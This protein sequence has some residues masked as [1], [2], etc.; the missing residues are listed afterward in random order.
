MSP[1]ASSSE[2]DGTNGP[3][4]SSQSHQLTSSS[5]LEGSPAPV[6][7]QPSTSRQTGATGPPAAPQSPRRPYA[8]FLRNRPAS[9]S[10]QP[11]S[12]PE[13]P[14]SRLPGS[15]RPAPFDAQQSTSQQTGASEPL[16]APRPV[17][18]SYA[19]VLRYQP[20]SSSP[21]PR[22]SSELPNSR[23]PGSPVAV[24]RSS[25][26]IAQGRTSRLAPMMRSSP[27]LNGTTRSPSLSNQ[28]PVLL[29]LQ[30]STP[31]PAGLRPPGSPRPARLTSPSSFSSDAGQFP[32]LQ[33]SI[34]GQTG[35]SR[36]SEAPQLACRG[37]SSELPTLAGAHTSTRATTNDNV[38]IPSA[39]N[40]AAQEIP[41][42]NPP[43]T[44]QDAMDWTPDV[45]V[46]VDGTSRSGTGDIQQP[47]QTQQRQDGS[48]MCSTPPPPHSVSRSRSPRARNQTGFRS[49]E[50][51]AQYVS[52][53][54][55]RPLID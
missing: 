21:P 48:Q 43:G 47:T 24:L 42:P 6:D 22:S 8:A 52:L 46:T 19:A 26:P 10:P 25:P 13:L 2:R 36:P 9:S 16:A 28:S 7:A 49:R 23:L 44:S 1:G 38:P 18:L 55:L 3:P 20:A 51:S 54:S 34:I 41:A 12:T 29:P 33:T 4:D 32:P 15:P 35:E 14:N 53:P 50:D 31:D 45:D 5:D 11:R 27:L 17:R 30:R 39:Q 37:S 40:N